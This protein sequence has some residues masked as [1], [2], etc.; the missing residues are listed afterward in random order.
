M[1]NNNI[2]QMLSMLKGIQNPQ[3]MV[4]NLMQSNPQFKAMMNQIQQSGMTPQQYLNMYAQ[5]RG[6]DINQIMQ[7]ANQMGIKF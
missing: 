7:Q 2:F 5:Q 1:N 3:M 4:N 6:L